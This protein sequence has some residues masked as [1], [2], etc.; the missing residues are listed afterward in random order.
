MPAWEAGDVIGDVDAGRLDHLLDRCIEQS[1]ELG[2]TLALVVAQ[3]G[4]LVRE[5]YAPGTDAGT[6]LVSWSVAKSITHALIGLLV[7]DGLLHVDRPAPV[8]AWQ[9][10]ER[11]AITVQ[12]LLTMTSGLEFVEDYVDAGISHVI[13]MLFGSGREDHAAYAAA[14][15]LVAAPG[16]HWNYSS[17]TSNILARIAGDVI[18]G[19]RTGTEAYL[20]ERLF[21]PIGMSSATPKFDTSGT[22]VGSS[23]VYATARDFARFGLL[24]LHDGRWWGEQILP[25]GWVSH[26]RTPVPV[27]VPD[28]EQHG[29]GAHWWLWNRDPGTLAALGYECQRIIV[30][31]DRDVVVVR[32][33]KSDA[34]LQPAVDGV[35]DDVLHC[36]PITS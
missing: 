16:T 23:F 34:S 33:G 28:D 18:G 10:D 5:R 3:G 27:V 14:F 24:Y 19:G 2:Q 36:F 35:L 15:P 17:G 4:R 13:E 30:S 1:P 26:A 21:G 12:Q 8:S 6:T 11:A 20:Q 7:G 22:F 25:E 29:Y 31:P 9:R 32:L